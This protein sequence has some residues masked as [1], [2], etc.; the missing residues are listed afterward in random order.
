MGGWVVGCGGVVMASS[1]ERPSLAGRAKPPEICGKSPAARS[2]K[3]PRR[4][5]RAPQ[6]P[7]KSCAAN[8]ATLSRSC[9]WTRYS[10]QIRPTL[11]D[12]GQLFA[13]L[14][15]LL[16]TSCQISTNIGRCCLNLDRCGP[17]C[18]TIWRNSCNVGR[19]SQVLSDI[20]QNL[21]EN[22][23]DRS[24]AISCRTLANMGD[25][26]R[27]LARVRQ[28]AAKIRPIVARIRPPLGDID[29]NWPNSSQI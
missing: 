8:A 24:W 9:S 7:S 10:T 25:V 26:G 14:G 23:L 20:S 15:G 4:P 27:S 11:A 19:C 28:Y 16:R 12:V 18:T 1:L 3:F 5:R 2:R 21:G 6:L 29:R 13:H 22:D 17:Y